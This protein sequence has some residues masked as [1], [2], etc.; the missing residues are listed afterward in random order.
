MAQRRPTRT[1]SRRKSPLPDPNGP[2]TAVVILGL[3]SA[4]TWGAGDFGGGS[5]ARRAPLF[6]VVLGTQAVGIVVALLL[7]TAR[8]EPVPQGT[9][10][11]WSL[12]SGLCGVV[13]ISALYR[14]LAVGRMGVVAPVTGVLG[15]VVPVLFGFVTEGLPGPTAIVGI[16][17]ALVAVVL[18]TQAPG[19]SSG[20]PSGLRWA[21]LAGSA[22]GLFNICIGQLSPAG[23]FGPLV[24]I[25]LVQA[26]VLGALILA[27]RQP[28]RVERRLWG[29]LVLIGVLDMTGN[30]AFIF[31]TQAG[32][33][34]IASIL[35]SL[36]PVVTVILAI[37]ILR[38][39]LTRSHVVGVALTGVAIVLIGLG[40]ATL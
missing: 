19:H 20:H 16:A 15:A 24:L 12:A 30:A 3:V 31:A 27:W 39:R 26:I 25:R 29:P 22:I 33:L 18:V 35:S 36:Y 34:A 40:S 7:G 38:E 4:I 2:G 10:I 13:G 21:L 9:D 1:R 37:V 14:G 23:A 6:G 17:T 11:L 28:W 32:Q 8:G 5:L